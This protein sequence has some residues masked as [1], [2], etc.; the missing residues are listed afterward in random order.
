VHF[1]LCTSSSSESFEPGS[2]VTA[3]YSIISVTFF[4]ETAPELFGRY[5]G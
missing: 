2:L 3:I 5:G 4:S 1:R